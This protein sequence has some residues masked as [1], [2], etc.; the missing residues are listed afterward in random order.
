PNLKLHLIGL[1]CHAGAAEG[2]MTGYL[3]RRIPSD[4]QERFVFEGL[5]PRIQLLDR[6]ARAT[7]CVFPAPWDNFPYTCCEAMSRSA[8]VIASREGGMGELIEP[9]RSGIL[10]DPN[11]DHDLER[12]IR[13]VLNGRDV[14][15]IR[16]RAAHRVRAVCDPGV[17]I[18][19]R[20]THY[21]R[22]IDRWRQ[23]PRTI[24][25]IN[26]HPSV[27][28]SA[29][30][31][32]CV[33]LPSNSKKAH[34]SVALVEAAAKHAGII[35]DIHCAPAAIDNNGSKA[36]DLNETEARHLS[37]W[38]EIV[39]EKKPQ[40]FLT[41]LPGDKLDLKYFKTTLDLL[42]NDSQPAWA[43][44]W[45]RSNGREDLHSYSG[46]DFQ[47]PLELTNYCPVPFA[48]I[49]R[50]A[51]D[52][53]GGW[54]FDL[55][56]AWRAWDLWLAFAQAGFGGRVAPAWQAAYGHAP[57]GLEV[58]DYAMSHELILNHIVTRN[59]ELFSEYGGTLW[60]FV[61]LEKAKN[62]RGPLGVFGPDGALLL[63]MKN[64]SKGVARRT[65]RMR[66]RLSGRRGPPKS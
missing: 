2:S 9:D 42:S 12:A 46:M 58:P 56:P 61:Q 7:A 5:V 8:C 20:V 39:G 29:A 64:A 34:E 51:F 49:R 53:V 27:A 26:V 47:V 14:S 31:I 3:R 1:D 22:T 45:T 37:A 6:Y 59:R 25:P 24:H 21:E 28:R 62:A 55:P 10:F 4:L 33:Y 16:K 36:D 44:T 35:V 52:E 18:P 23:T 63:L 65:R 48:V 30:P 11:E 57:P 19:Q 13:S 54:N 40:Y 38:L 43:T 41:L 17:V 66:N 32:V 60:A 15:E 50:S